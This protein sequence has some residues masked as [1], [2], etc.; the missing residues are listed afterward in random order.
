MCRNNF[1]FGN[2]FAIG[3]K[4]LKNILKTSQKLI[5]SKLYFKHQI[6]K[7][8]IFSHLLQNNRTFSIFSTNIIKIDKTVIIFV[9]I[10]LFVILIL[11]LK[12]F[13]IILYRI[14]IISF[15]MY[16]TSCTKN[17]ISLFKIYNKLYDS[18]L[19]TKHITSTFI[20]NYILY[21]RYFASRR[22]R[23]SRPVYHTHS[24]QR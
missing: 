3:I 23:W 20:R 12:L 10:F 5:L 21:Q 24:K 16:N 19:L 1:E 8:K 14:T 9:I 13:Q 2:K 11:I 15:H 18:A 6:Q 4:K 22:D 7:S 17:E